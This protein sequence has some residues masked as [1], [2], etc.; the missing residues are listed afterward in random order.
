M[1][2]F[3]AI[4]P[5]KT[6]LDYFRDVI[7]KFD[8][9]KRNLKPINLEQMH[10]TVRF[11]GANV[12]ITSKNRITQALRELE[13]NF[14][15]PNIHIDNLSFGFKYQYDPRVLIANIEPNDDLDDLV[16]MIHRTIR[17]QKRRDTIIWKQPQDHKYHIS[18]ARLKPAATRSTGRDIKEILK[19]INLETPPDFVPEEMHLV[20]SVI[21][22]TGPI[23]K[24]LES[25]KL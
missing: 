21:T 13:G 20:E 25:I 19:T 4:Y 2:L 7:R 22:K 14:P 15:K 10:L 23:Y 3:L 5:P 6:Y 16:N 11:I 12:G 17:E 18:L 1:R 9:E 24:K 8:K